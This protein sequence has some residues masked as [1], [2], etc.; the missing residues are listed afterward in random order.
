MKTIYDSVECNDKYC[1]DL[2]WYS[3]ANYSIST[4]YYGD[5]KNFIEE[6]IDE[7]AFIRYKSD[8][9]QL[10]MQLNKLFRQK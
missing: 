10:L 1:D 3:K 7:P 2:I 4:E 9:S 8:L 6:I 5:V